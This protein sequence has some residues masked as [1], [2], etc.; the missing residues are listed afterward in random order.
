[1]SGPPPVPTRLKL[2]R[3]N[4]GHSRLRPEPEPPRLPECPEPHAHVTGYAAEDWR[5][6]GPEL[7]QLGLLTVADT[8]V[9]EGYCITYGRW[10]SRHS[11]PTAMASASEKRQGTK[12]RREI[13]CGVAYGHP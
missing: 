12:S 1:M 2:I 11:T 10:R 8:S 6:I 7:H 13:G 9:F 5:R 3:G 4:P